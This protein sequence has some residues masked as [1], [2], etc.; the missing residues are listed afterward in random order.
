M[1]GAT[2]NRVARNLIAALCVAVT[3]TVAWAGDAFDGK[4]NLLCTVQQLHECDSFTGCR[5]LD[6]DVALPLQHLAVDFKNRAVALHGLEADL[7]SSISGVASIEGQLIVQGTDTGLKDET[8]GG[9]WTMAINQTYGS[10][11]LTVAGHDV[12]FV[13]MGNCVTAR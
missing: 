11:L 12:A 3:S 1:K 9:G 2:M 7:S 4:T 13:G 5:A 6:V 8:D 10:L